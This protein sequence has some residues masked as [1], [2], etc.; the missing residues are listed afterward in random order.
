MDGRAGAGGE[1]EEEGVIKEAR[2]NKPRILSW[3]E[4][5]AARAHT[6]FKEE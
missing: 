3:Q 2:L 4:I 1:E 5:N 6:I